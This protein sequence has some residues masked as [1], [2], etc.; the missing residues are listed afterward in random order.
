MLLPADRILGAIDSKFQ[1]LGSGD[2]GAGQGSLQQSLGVAVRLL[3]Q[4]EHKGAAGVVEQLATLKQALLPLA[5]PMTDFPEL[6]Q[7]LATLLARLDMLL[8]TQGIQDLETGWRDVL[9]HTENWVLKVGQNSQ[10]PT[11]ARATLTQAVTA[12]ETADLQS[13]LADDSG[14]KEQTVELDA[15]SLQTY[16]QHRFAD[17]ALT[18]NRLLPLAGG[19]GKQTFLFDVE[20][21][22]LN[23]S[24]VMRRDSRVPLLEHGC[25]RV[26]REF[27][28]IRAAYDRGF[29]APEALWVDTSHELLPGG[30]FLVMKCSPGEAGGSV[31]AAQGEIPQ[32]LTQTLAGI[33]ARLH[34]LPPMKELSDASD[35]ISSERWA[36]PLSDC[37]FRYLSDWFQTFLNAVHLPSPAIITQFNWLLNN[38][39]QAD[40]KPVLLHGDI[41]FHNFL[42]DKGQLVAV[43][44]WEFAHLGDPAEDLAYVRNTLG[45]ALD[46]PAFMAAYKAEGGHEVDEK[47]LHFFQVWGHL[48]NAASSNIAAAKF[49]NGQADDL[50]MVILP[51]L[52]IPLFLKTAQALIDQAPPGE[53]E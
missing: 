35:S 21:R 13:Q 18:V 47:R 48:R 46:W 23:G 16:L 41:G 37:V 38:V 53:A 26:H 40:G 39:P 7:E 4:R 34:N 45:A 51:H 25:H 20:G 6:T 44:D 19:F 9:A 43:L 52:Y 42:F 36:L 11:E 10:V 12:W 2:G 29:P 28:V 3:R 22:E 5:N 49:A 30:N 24:F 17:P 1:H 33:L 27:E 31:F 15:A 50:K 14:T 8:D 32:D